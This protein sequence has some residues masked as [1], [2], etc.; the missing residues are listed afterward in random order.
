MNR[1]C[2][3]TS[4]S[5]AYYALVSRLRRAGLPFSSLVPESDFDA[6]D[7]ILTTEDESERFGSRALALERLDENPGVFKGQVLSRLGGGEED[8]ILVGVDPGKR[9]GVA[10]FYGRIE[11]SS[12]TLDSVAAVCSRVAAF[13]NAVPASRVLVRIGDGNRALAEKLAEGFGRVVPAASLELVDESGTSARSSGMKGVQRDQ[14]AAARIAF[15]KGEV[16]GRATRNR[17]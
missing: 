3:V 4:K 2:V 6:C 15:R 10:V 7:L 17:V 13:V 11:L 5:R 14:V 8:V 12:H 1:I 9:M 16:I